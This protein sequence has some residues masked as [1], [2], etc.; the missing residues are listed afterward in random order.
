M[1]KITL[2]D[3]NVK[4]FEV[5]STAMDV[6]KSI[7][8]GFA[9]N[10]ISANFN[11]TTVETST[12]LTTDGSLIL[13]TFNDDGGKKA[14]WHSSAH[15]LAQAILE[16]HPTAKLTIGPA[17]DNGFYYDIDLGDETISEKDFSAIEKKFLELA[18]GKHEFKLRSISKADALSYYKEEGNQY[19]VELIENL[20]DGDIT[21]CDHSDFTDLCRGGHIPNT[22]IIKAIKVMNVAGAYW[23]GDEKNN[24]LTRSIWYFFS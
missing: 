9:R 8:E 2:P 22:G 5:N 1:I 4:E 23:R 17:I 18:R 13:Y 14:F 15:V 3:G 21:F 19:K 16:F 7:S 10:V 24:Q 12:P 6:A 20:T 11:G